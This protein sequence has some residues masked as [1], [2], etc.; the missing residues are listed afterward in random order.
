[1]TSK[2]RWAV[3]V[4]ALVAMAGPAHSQTRRPPADRRNFVTCPVVRD[5]KTVPCWLAEFQ[6]ELYFLGI[7]TDTSADWYPPQLGHEVL[8]EGVVSSGPRVCGGIPLKPVATSVMPE[9]NPA[10]GT[11]LPAEPGIEAP[12]AERGPGPSSERRAGGTSPQTPA[13]PSP[14][15]AARTF[16]IPFDFDSNIMLL[17]VTRRMEQA[18]RYAK[19][20]GPARIEVTGYRGATLLSDGRTIVESAPIAERRAAKLGAILR[21]LGMPSV[22][23]K[24]K[25]S[26]EPAD[27]VKD[28][29]RRRATVIV[30]PHGAG[31]VREAAARRP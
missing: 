13:P 27:G 10:C 18:V 28:A 15:F 7:Q 16:V 3:A 26:P 12:H 21:G 23:V 2:L 8:V 4:L 22:V 1:M 6:G 19:A 31:T 5:T 24:W 17:R 14:P 11:M 20:I 25:T 30:T 29:E 9:L